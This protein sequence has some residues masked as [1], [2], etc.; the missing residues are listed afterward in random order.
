MT[1]KGYEIMNIFKGLKYSKDHEWVRM[2]GTKAFIGI[3]NYAQLALGDIVFVELPKPETKLAA[4]DAIGVVESVKTAS[5]IYTPISGTIADINM[6]LVDTPEM[7]NAEPYESWIA[8]VEPSD[9]C[10]LDLL[11]NEEEYGEFCIKEG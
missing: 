3:T 1:Q 4:G 9:V 11:M 7:L 6:K 10:E 2:E 8:V 5:D